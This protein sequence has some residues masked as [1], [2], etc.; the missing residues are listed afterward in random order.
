MSTPRERQP[1]SVRVAAVQMVSG[2]KVDANLKEAERVIAIAVGEGARLVALPEYFPIM[3]MHELDKVK[4]RE[5]PGKGPIQEFLADTAR[6]HRIWLVGGS[7]P[8][9]A[10]VP[11]KVLNT[12]LVYDEEG[13]VVAR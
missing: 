11:E 12:T 4:V 8:L 9:A 6:R 3:G 5:E 1:G 7:V 10:S 13:R 2:A